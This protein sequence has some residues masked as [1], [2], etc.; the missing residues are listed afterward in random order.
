MTG[1][2]PVTKTWQ[3]LMLPLH[4]IRIIWSD[5]SDGSLKRSTR[6]ELVPKVWKTQMLPLHYDR[7]W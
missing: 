3:A 5:K 4:H 6:L 1:I 7:I 2:E